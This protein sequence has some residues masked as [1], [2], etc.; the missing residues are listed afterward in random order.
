MRK[1]IALHGLAQ[2]GKTTAAEYLVKHWGFIPITFADPIKAMIAAMCGVT[3]EQLDEA[4]DKMLP[5]MDVSIRE[6][7]QTLGTDWGRNM[8]DEDIWV[9]MVSEQIAQYSDN[10][11]IVVTDCRFENEAA[12][13]REKGGIVAHIYRPDVPQM[14]HESEA[15]IEF[16]PTDYTLLNKSSKREFY[17][18]VDRLVANYEKLIKLRR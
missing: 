16:E 5:H 6:M 15:G 8:I 14:D 12:L 1:L 10:V 11:D 2:S 18:Y 9:N 13:I 7:F 3:V 4:K 17:R